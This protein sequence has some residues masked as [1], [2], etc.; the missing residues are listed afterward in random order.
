[1][2]RKI[3]RFILSIIGLLLIGILLGVSYLQL[4]T[5]PAEKQASHVMTQAETTSSYTFFQGQENQKTIIIYPGALVESASYAFLAQRLQETGYNVY[6]ISSPLHLP[7]LDSQAALKIMEEKKIPSR[8]VVLVGHS[9]GGVVAAQNAEDI[10]S[11]GDQLAGL[12]LLASYPADSTD[13]SQ[14][15]LPVLSITAD[16]DKI[17]KMDRYSEAKNRLPQKTDYQLIQGGNHSGFGLYGQQKGD[18]QATISNLEQQDDIVK[19][20]REF[21]G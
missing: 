4:Q 5:Y 16:Q 17:I 9:L 8:K 1:M 12:V 18:G 13:L 15:D 3:Y 21:L 11:R 6:L 20:M 2:K 19:R 10:L 14:S 7:V